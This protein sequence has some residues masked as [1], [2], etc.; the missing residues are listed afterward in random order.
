MLRTILLSLDCGVPRVLLWHFP[1]SSLLPLAILLFGFSLPFRAHGDNA[2]ATLA[3]FNRDGTYQI[4]VS[5]QVIAPGDPALEESISPEAAAMNN[6]V[7]EIRIQFDEVELKPL[8]GALKSVAIPE[9]EGMTT[10]VRKAEGYMPAGSSQFLLHLGSEATVALVMA[11]TRDGVEDRRRHVV[12][13]GQ[14]SRPIDLRSDPFDADAPIT[15][16]AAFRQGF[17]W[18]LSDS[19]KRGLMIMLL[20][21]Y[22][23]NL[24]LS[25]ALTAAWWI[26]ATMAQIN[27]EASDMTRPAPQTQVGLLALGVLALSTGLLVKP[28]DHFIQ[29]PYL[30][31]VGAGIAAGSST[32]PL[33]T[34]AVYFPASGF[35]TAAIACLCCFVLKPMWCQ[36]SY[37]ANIARPASLVLAGAS[38]SW[39]ILAVFGGL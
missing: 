31:A 35:G 39:L 26:A 3:S 4:Q 9:L 25:G 37:K 21:I 2:V 12:V 17:M 14:S 27:L 6:I 24:R 38:V 16:G 36:D 30:F 28:D 29:Y 11:V 5:V 18:P 32:W 20:C 34:Q 10:L 1:V 23:G 22:A 7:G 8:F 33:V 19:A 15:A 13:P